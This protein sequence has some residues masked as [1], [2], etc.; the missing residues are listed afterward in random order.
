MRKHDNLGQIQKFLKRWNKLTI[1]ESWGVGKGICVL[2]D[3]LFYELTGP[4]QK[5]H[6]AKIKFDYIFQ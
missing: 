1:L 4:V 2:K 3:N 6:K 5:Q